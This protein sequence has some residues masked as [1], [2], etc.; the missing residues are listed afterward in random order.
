MDKIFRGKCLVLGDNIDTD[1]IIP[2]RFLR[3][4][5][6]ENYALAGLG[7]EMPQKLRNFS[8]IVAGK[9]FGCGSSREQATVALKRAGI[10]CIVAESFARI[11]YRNAINV[12]L[13]V[14]EC[15]F[16]AGGAGEGD[17][18]E[19]ELKSGAVRNKTKG[20]E[21]QAAPLSKFALDVLEAGGLIPYYKKRIE[22]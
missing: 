1:V 12:G 6:L 3:E 7:A 20:T 22:G 21:A 5:N 14:V 13:P 19:V 17:E 10:K 4:K 2:G 9:N 11:F 16:G 8:F 15:S 18:L